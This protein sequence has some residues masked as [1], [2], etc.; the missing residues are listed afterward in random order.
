VVKDERQ[1][2]TDFA[3]CLE[4]IQELWKKDD[5]DYDEGSSREPG[6]KKQKQS[7]MNNESMNNERMNKKKKIMV[8]GALEG[9]FDQ[10]MDNVNTLLL[11]TPDP[12]ERYVFLRGRH[13]VAC[14]L[15]PG[16]HRIVTE[17]RAAA[18]TTTT[19]AEARREEGHYNL[20]C[21]LIPLDGPCKVI[22]QGL[23]WNLGE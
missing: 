6:E 17:K 12:G 18:A 5:H 22:T 15:P 2:N 13:S 20:S 9:R 4:H 16:E 1:D 23:K 10:T 21:G 7:E 3:K 19:E 14:V 11:L 8:L